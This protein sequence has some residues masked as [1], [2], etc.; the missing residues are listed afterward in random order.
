VTAAD[1]C[2]SRSASGIRYNINTNVYNDAKISHFECIQLLCQR[3]F[4]Y[5]FFLP[6][7]ASIIWSSLVSPQPW[8]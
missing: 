4:Q 5:F 3:W 7:L 1:R 2:G 6:G 8:P